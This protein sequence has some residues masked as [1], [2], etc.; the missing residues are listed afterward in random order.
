MVLFLV[1][2]DGAIGTGED[3]GPAADAFFFV[4]GNNAGFRVFGE[5]TGETG[6][7][8]G[9]LGAVMAAHGKGYRLL[10]FDADAGKRLR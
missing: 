5:R 9:W 1:L 3:A 4:N 10:F 7:D 6:I 2:L 8:A